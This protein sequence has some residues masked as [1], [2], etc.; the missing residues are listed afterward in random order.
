MSKFSYAAPGEVGLLYTDEQGGYHLLAL[1]KEQHR[2]L[3]IF[4]SALTKEQPAL[5]VD[6]FEVI[7]KEKE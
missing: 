7:I 4:V 1:S 5:K 2:A 3:N 6:Q